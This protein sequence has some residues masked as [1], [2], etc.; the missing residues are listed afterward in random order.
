MTP[1]QRLTDRKR[2]AI[3]QA[4]IAEFRA[5]GF[6][7]TSVDK[8]AARAE[9]SK[10]TLYNHFPSKDEL[11]AE[12]LREL[13]RCSTSQAE[14]PYEPGLPLR[15]QLL[16]LAM[17]KMALLADDSFLDLARVAISAALHAPERARDMLERLGEKESG[18]LT[19]I[20]AAQKDGRL[21]P[22]DAALAAQQLESLVKGTAF[23]PQVAMGQPKL[24]PKAQRQVAAAAVDLFLSHYAA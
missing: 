19:W 2:E 24:S 20:R 17:Q 16:A 15:G 18:M 13:W 21:K 10:R 23:W 5:Q 8:V 14:Q 7:A 4:A 9:V 22:G 12:I 6:D 1:V 11:F 3:V